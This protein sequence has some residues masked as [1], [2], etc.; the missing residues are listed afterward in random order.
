MVVTDVCVCVGVC[1][2]APRRVHIRHHPSVACNQIFE[3]TK[4]PPPSPPP[5]R[6][7]VF[8]FPCPTAAPRIQASLPVN[9]QCTSATVPQH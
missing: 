7:P 6:P 9:L 5:L 8:F 3:Q 1:V 4:A 2:G